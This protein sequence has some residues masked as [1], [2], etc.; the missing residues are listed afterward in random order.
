[1]YLFKPLLPWILPET[2][3]RL[4]VLDCDAV[5]LRDIRE[6]FGEFSKFCGALVGVGRE[7]SLLYQR[8][9]GLTG[10][11]GG[12]QLLDLA[13]MRTSERYR[14]AL[15]RAAAGTDGRRKTWNQAGYLGDQTFYSLLA[16]DQPGTV[17]TLPC[18][19]N[20]QLGSDFTTSNRHADSPSATLSPNAP[21][22]GFTND[23]VHS[24]RKRCALLHA[25]L[26]PLKCIARFMHASPSCST[27]AAFQRALIDPRG[28]SQ[29]V[30]DLL[31]GSCPMA[32]RVNRTFLASSISRFFAGCCITRYRGP[33]RP[34]EGA[35][36][37]A[38]VA[39]SV[40]A[41]HRAETV[42]AMSRRDRSKEAWEHSAA[43]VA[44]AV[45]HGARSPTA[46]RCA[47]SSDG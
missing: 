17:H 39:A 15:E 14:V 33:V 45:S 34:P 21:R 6:L 22:P 18:E 20:R 12:V 3:R 7:Q 23:S 4:I 24:C 46:V 27:W 11:N 8:S 35:L 26:G 47:P 37:S 16:A 44:A 13:A 1:M 41:A 9:L 40:R 5:P 30:H 25:N 29:S 19:W 42:H 36:G 28:S 2:V 10:Y 43:G 32:R 31:F 38:R